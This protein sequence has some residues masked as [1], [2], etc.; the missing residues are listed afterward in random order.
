MNVTL[1]NTRKDPKGRGII[2]TV[3]II[4][5]TDFPFFR[6]AYALRALKLLLNAAA[7]ET[8]S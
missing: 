5:P 3:R 6:V 7:Q 8:Q 1:A 2:L 4:V